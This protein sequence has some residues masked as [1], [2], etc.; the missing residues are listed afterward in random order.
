VIVLGL[1][2]GGIVMSIL[3]AVLSVNELAL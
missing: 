1:V 3:T 2:V